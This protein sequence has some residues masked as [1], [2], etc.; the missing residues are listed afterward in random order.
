MLD[1]AIDLGVELVTAEL[2]LSSNAAET[3]TSYGTPLSR[4]DE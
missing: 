2:D 4:K 1:N 3:A